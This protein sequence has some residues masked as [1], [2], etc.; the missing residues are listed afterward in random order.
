MSKGYLLI[1]HNNQSNDYVKQAIYCAQRIKM[2]CN[3]A[4][5]S[6]IT[7][8]SDY[9]KKLPGF[10]VFEHVVSTVVKV[11]DNYKLSFDG[12]LSNKTVKWINAG[13]DLAYDL[14]PYDET[15][16][17]DTDYIVSNSNLNSCFGSVNDFMLFRNS[18]YV[19][20]VEVTDEFIRCSDYSIDF[21]WATV[22]YFKK[23]TK[24]K[25]LFDTVQHIRNNWVYYNSLYQINSGN[26][27]NDYAFSIAL[28]ML[29][30]TTVATLPGKMYYIKDQD[31]LEKIDNDKMIFLV[32]KKD[33]LGEYTLL[34]TEGL[35]V[36]VLNKSSLERIIE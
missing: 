22:I 14:S 13:R 34:S 7:S 33:H 25:T 5:V 31:F 4:S 28:H 30:N 11:D 29:N 1:A 36:H 18:K 10:E 12:A 27:R 32:G 24:S 23:S 3:D 2:F 19:G 9:L 8:N 35:N 26:F 15:I 20:S 21:Y 17:L 6:I 16:L